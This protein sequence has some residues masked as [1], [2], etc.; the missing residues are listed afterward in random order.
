MSYNNTRRAP[1]LNTA[2][3][4]TILTTLL[5]VVGFLFIFLLNVGQS[6]FKTVEAQTAT[7][8]V[9]VLN[10]PPAFDLGEE[11]REETESS[12]ST[13]TNSGDEFAV[14]GTAT[15]Q[16]GAPYFLLV[17]DDDTNPP[18]AQANVGTP[19]TAPPQCGAGANLIAV[20]AAATSG[21]LAR[22]ATT[23]T[24]AF[25]EQ[26]PWFAWACDD[27]AVNPECTVASFQG[28]G[29]TSSPFNVN[30]RPTFT[31]I[32]E[33][34][35]TDPGGLVTFT[36]TADD[37]DTV[38]DD[39]TLQLFVCN[40]NDYDTV[41]NTCGIGGTFASSSFSLS[42]PVATATLPA[43]VQDGPRDAFVFV[44]DNHGHEA[45]GG[46]QAANE[47]YTVANVAPTIDGALIT[48]N[49][50]DDLTLT[51]AANET[52]GFT[53]SFIANDANSCEN[54]AAGAEI[55][56]YIA[57]VHRSGIGSS[58]CDVLSD[59]NPNNCYTTEVPP[60]TW[61]ISCAATTTGAGV[62]GGSTDATELWECTF[63]LWYVADPTDPAPVTPL[64]E[65]EDW[66]ASISA[67]DDNNA[68]S[69]FVQS[70]TPGIEV[71]SFLSFEL[72]ANAIPYGDLAPG[73][74]TGNLN[75][76]TT[77]RATGNVGIDQELS[78]LRMCPGTGQL[79]D[80]PNS[81]TSSIPEGQQEFATS[82]VPYTTGTDLPATTTPSTLD[83]NVNKPTST[84]TPTSEIIYWGLEV[85]G[86]ITLAGTYTGQN[87]FMAVT[88]N[89]AQW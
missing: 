9:N 89:A 83:L 88:S 48:L 74:N 21:T 80:C 28:T 50:G 69:S 14:I 64:F 26:T 79:G 36:A 38:D 60:A 23:T 72:A 75:A 8:S 1:Y 59:Y 15:D 45:T 16:N 65:A 19:G 2:G 12:T 22:A 67:I 55:V 53:L 42:N 71:V 13:P 51:E 86:T 35:P 73:D 54:T 11:P 20:S 7:T 84:S 10:T 56:D 4:V 70:T 78:G 58:S 39:D 32:A 52:T 27:D 68:T 66:R 62:C 18:V 63:P 61:N 87:T 24:E 37:S 17:C 29:S 81:A 43:I 76:T 6:E 34:S 31:A 47:G 82:S 30:H 77:V 46:Q 44:V 33:D 57:S 5:G 40:A 85:P 49:G 3:K 41:T 25:P